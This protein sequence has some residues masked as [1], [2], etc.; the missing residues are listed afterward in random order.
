VHIVT[1]DIKAVKS[2]PFYTASKEGDPRAAEG[3]IEDFLDEVQL[4]RFQD[5]LKGSSTFLLAVHA[6]ESEGMNAIPRVLARKLSA[7][8][9]IP[10][11]SGVIQINRVSHTGAD[12]YHRLAFPAAFD[13]DVQPAE[14]FLIDD[15]RGQG[16]TLANLRGFLESR[17]ARVVG[18]AALTGKAYSGNLTLHQSTLQSLRSKHGRDLEEWWSTAFGYGFEKLTESEGRYLRRADD[19][20]AISERLASARR[21]GDR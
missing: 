10:V 16:G 21:E 9:D 11:A 4:I 8:L 15:F 14:Y 13:G 19:A 12:G 2:H 17:G 20:N 7:Q 18:A 5:V 3:L 6:L 1:N